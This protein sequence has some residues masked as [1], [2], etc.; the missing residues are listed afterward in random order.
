MKMSQE[1][2][3][4]AINKWGI[5]VQKK[6]IKEEAMEFALAVEQSECPTKDQELAQQRIY[7]ELADLQIVMQYVPLLYNQNKLDRIKEMKIKKFK[8]KYNL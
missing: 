5:E 6:K 8:A 3:K 1:L 2:L 4:A 7:E